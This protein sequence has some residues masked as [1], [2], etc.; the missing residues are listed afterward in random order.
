MKAS[1]FLENVKGINMEY[2]E[3]VDSDTMEL[4]SSGSK[5]LHPA[6]CIAAR[7]E[8]IRLIDNMIKE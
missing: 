3:W 4:I 5:I 2:L 6:I 1:R 7:V 8:N